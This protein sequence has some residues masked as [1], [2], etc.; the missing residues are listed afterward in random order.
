[1][2]RGQAPFFC[3][4]FLHKIHFCSSQLIDEFKNSHLKRNLS[5]KGACPLFSFLF[6]FVQDIFIPCEKLLE[7]I[8]GDDIPA[9]VERKRGPPAII[10]F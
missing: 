4:F 9:H 3:T 10:G 8:L 1:M 5:E 7:L 2:K 6:L